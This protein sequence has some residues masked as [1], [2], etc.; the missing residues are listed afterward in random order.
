MCDLT[1]QSTA[2]AVIVDVCHGILAQGILVGFERQR[3][4]TREADAGVIASANLGIDPET[5]AHDAP[6]RTD[7]PRQLGSQPPLTRELALTIGNDNLETLLRGA[8]GLA[9]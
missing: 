1:A 3:G 5:R 2:N 4:A 6:A 9:Q 7:E 8:H